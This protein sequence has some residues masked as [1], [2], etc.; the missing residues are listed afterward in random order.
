ML[1]TI[2]VGPDKPAET[3]NYG[4]QYEASSMSIPDTGLLPVIAIHLLPTVVNK[5]DIIIT[6]RRPTTNEEYYEHTEH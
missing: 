3:A 6:T 1:K 2:P 4:R 5:N